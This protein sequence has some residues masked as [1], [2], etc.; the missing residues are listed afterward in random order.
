MNFLK[1]TEDFRC[2]GFKYMHETQIETLMD[3]MDSA[4]SSAKIADEIKEGKEACLDEMKVKAEELVMLF[5]G[6][7][8]EEDLKSSNT[9]D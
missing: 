8:K 4:F 5:G 7:L 2:V 6:I 1:N 9:D 3:F